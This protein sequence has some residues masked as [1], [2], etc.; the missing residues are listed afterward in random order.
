MQNTIHQPGLSMPTIQAWHAL[1]SVL[2]PSDFL[3]YLALTSAIFVKYWS[4]FDHESK[5]EAKQILLHI[6]NGGRDFGTHLSTM[7][8]FSDIPE[9][10]G[11]QE[12]V[13]ASIQD[14]DIRQKVE[15]ICPRIADV[16][17]T[18]SQLAILEAKKLVSDQELLHPLISGDTF[19][20]CIGELI[21]AL[22]NVA[23]REGE[24]YEAARLATFECLG[25]IGAVDPDRFELPRDSEDPILMFADLSDERAS[26]LFAIHLIVNVLT[27]IFPKTSDIKFQSQLAY[28]I[29]EL[30]SFCGF[31][32]LLLSQEPE[33]SISVKTRARWK[34]LPD[35][36]RA[37]I[38]PLLSSKFT[39]EGSVENTNAH[40]IY[41]STS[42][43]RE[44]IQK[45][46]A[47]LIA[48]TS[49][50]NAQRIFRPFHAILG[51]SDVQVLLLLLPNLVLHL[52][53][54][55]SPD[56]IDHIRQEIVCVLEDQVDPKTSHT[57]DMR[58][59]CAQVCSDP[60][61]YSVTNS[62][63]RPYSN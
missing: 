43:Y 12:R 46:S 3:P 51:S 53:M 14:V 25:I 45:F 60:P 61:W 59:L 27:P 22:H 62:P 56:G 16:N 13:D 34:N 11:I 52:L 17:P 26:Q 42:T 23:N 1:A 20:P 33:S 18:V 7:A 6:V 5:L 49:G 29:Q 35:D 37:T 50:S 38:A 8:S 32:A 63:G 24:V 19:D 21:K 39:M 54:G 48:N 9:L 2:S 28:T 40:P 47:Y 4:S 57:G 55:S 31:T 44:W 30:L 10:Q 15:R 36:V 41:P 58:L